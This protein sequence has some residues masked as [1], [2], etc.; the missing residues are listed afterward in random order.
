MFA[1]RDTR[2]TWTIYALLLGLLTA[3]AYG[4]LA[5]QALDTDDFEYLRDAAAGA[6][7]LSL[8]FSDARELPGRPVAEIVFLLGHSLWGTEPAAFHLLVVALHLLTSLLLAQTFRRLGADLELSLAGGLLFLINVA[9]FRAVQWIACLVYPLAL[10]LGLVVILLFARYLTTNRRSLLFGALLVQMLAILAHAGSVCAAAFC[11]YLAWRRTRRPLTAAPLLA[12][13]AAVP[14]LLHFLYPLAPQ[15]RET[16]S[17]VDPVAIGS[18]FL[19]YIGRSLSAAHWLVA[20]QIQTA[21]I[22][23]GAV[24]L[25][26]AAWLVARRRGPEADWAV[27][28]LLALLPFAARATIEPSRF[29]YMSSAGASLVL[30]WLLRAGCGQLQRFGGTTLPR[31]ATSG[32]LVALVAAS[33]FSLHKAESLAFYLSARSHDARGHRQAALTLYKEAFARDPRLIPADGY[34]RMAT[35]GFRWGDACRAELR[36]GVAIHAGHPSLR[37]LAQIGEFLRTD[38]TLYHHT[39]K[40]FDDAEH[41]LATT[42]PLR[43]QGAVALHH[44]GL[45]YA[46]QQQTRRAVDAFERALT[47]QP[48]YELALGGLA[49]T[50]KQNGQIDLAIDHYRRFLHQRPNMAIGHFSLAALLIKKQDL[51]KAIEALRKGV[52]LED[53]HPAFWYKLAVLYR[54]TAQAPEAE[55]AIKKALALS[56]DSRDYWIEYSNVAFLYHSHKQPLKAVAIYEE[57]TEAIPAYSAAHFNLGLLQYR[58]GHYAEAVA[59]FRQVVQLSPDDDEAHRVLAL[60]TDRMEKSVSA[61]A[62]GGN[63]G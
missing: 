60:A 27:F 63:E 22:A 48:N 30:A 40:A 45:Y 32:A 19:G 12:A 16:L 28:A 36:R 53:H 17:V 10:S 47:L 46:E 15:S 59:S 18:Q 14:M 39:A 37:L 11:L 43:R 31:L 7:N 33:T 21:E 24:A 52:A 61:L 9:H 23:A 50:Y 51:P 6:Q 20:G 57:V 29:L 25:L 4:G 54:A 44:I 3:V 8:L 55:A 58:Q 26:A 5:A 38:S 49:E 41:K 2:T 42:S 35:A 62:E 56:G 13:A 1:L 34:A